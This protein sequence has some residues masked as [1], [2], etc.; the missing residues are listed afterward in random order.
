MQSVGECLS[1]QQPRCIRSLRSQLPHLSSG[2][3]GTYNS[4]DMPSLEK[5]V[6]SQSG[7]VGAFCGFLKEKNIVPFTHS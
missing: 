4:S 2:K 1:L 6:Y 5:C 3:N 7:V